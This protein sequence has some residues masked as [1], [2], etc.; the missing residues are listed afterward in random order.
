MA[1]ILVVL[2]VCQSDYSSGSEWRCLEEGEEAGFY[3]KLDDF[4]LSGIPEE[5][6]LKVIVRDKETK[7]DVNNIVIDNI[8]ENYRPVELHDCGVYVV[9]LFNYDPKKTKQN[10]GY[11]DEFWKYDYSGKGKS[12]I[13][14]SEKPDEYVSYYG[15][16][17]RVDPLERYVVLEKG[18]SDKEYYALVIKDL[19]TKEDVFILDYREMLKNYPEL[20]G[21]FGMKEWTRDGR[22]FFGDIFYGANVSAYFR[23]DTE[24]WT[25]EIF[26]VPEGQMGGD[27]L[28]VETGWVTNHTG[29]FWTGEYDSTK[30]IEA[31]MRS[32]GIGTKFYLYNL[33]TKEKILVYET[34]E[35]N[36]YTKPQWLSETEVEYELPSGEKRVYE[37]K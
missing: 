2:G 13:L 36:W 7:E 24:T 15:P 11:K 6:P 30:S 29:T 12:L 37:L 8:F 17:F 14:L 5:Y 31:K 10:I 34:D 32:Q 21:G 19:E 33:L 22:Y 23:I 18:H 4:K 35:P 3:D 28:N 25:Y 20:L 1:I 27:Q 26:D 9:K 16:V